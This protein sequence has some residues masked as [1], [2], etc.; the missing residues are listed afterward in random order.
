MLGLQ[1]VQVGPLF[2]CWI[3]FWT[4]L[5][6]TGPREE[7][8][9]RALV[10][11][12]A[13]ATVHVD[14]LCVGAIGKGLLV[15]VGVAAGDLD[16]DAAWLATKLTS[17]RIFAD[18]TGRMNDSVLDVSGDVLLVSQ[19]TLCADLSKG[20][21]PSFVSAMDPVPARVAF[22]GFVERMRILVAAPARVATGQFGAD[23]KVTLCNDGPVTLWLDTQVS[24]AGAPVAPTGNTHV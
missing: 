23:M 17:L 8:R 10:Q 18:A 3:R 16:R 14:G 5:E 12:V 11:R 1:G 4:A 6:A 13:E 22:D 21:R 19:F 9:V 24:R 15:F 7:H 2:Y 20:A